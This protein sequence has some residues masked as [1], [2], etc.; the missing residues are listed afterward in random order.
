MIALL[1][2]RAEKL[3]YKAINASVSGKVFGGERHRFARFF[4]FCSDSY[5]DLL[6]FGRSGAAYGGAVA[7]QTRRHT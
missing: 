1:A 7:P 2:F 4:I 3:P 5:V 6:F